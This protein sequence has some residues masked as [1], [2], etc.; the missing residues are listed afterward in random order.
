MKI[1]NSIILPIIPILVYFDFPGTSLGLNMFLCLIIF[2]NS[3]VILLREKNKNI[4]WNQWFLFLCLIIVVNVSV[5]VIKYNNVSFF[6]IIY[7]FINLFTIWIISSKNEIFINKKIYILSLIIL[8]LCSIGIYCAQW[9]VFVI[10]KKTFSGMIP[11]LEI[12]DS[13]SKIEATKGV[14]LVSNG[15]SSNSFC[16]FFS[17]PSHFAMFLLPPLHFLYIYKKRKWYYLAIAIVLFLTIMSTRSGNGIIGLF[18]LSFLDVCYDSEIEKRRK[19]II[20]TIISISLL[21]IF[22]ISWLIPSFREM[23]LRLFV[24]TEQGY[25]KAGYR[26]YRGFTIFFNLPVGNAIYGLGY[27]QITRFMETN[28]FVTMFDYDSGSVE[29]VNFICQMMI[30]FG[31]VGFLTFV[32]FYIDI[33]RN[34]DNCSKPLLI[35]LSFFFLSCSML[36]DYFF[37]FYFFSAIVSNRNANNQ[38]AFENASL[39]YCLEI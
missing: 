16:S 6:S 10:T 36:F 9:L 3:I 18:I 31:L 13:F 2:I 22:A 17:E 20:L 11:F 35:L 26:I 29:Y 4:I 25:S 7:L 24:A 1:I 15:S 14:Y 5:V 37:M 30:Y 19:K 34:C 28:S 33:F 32:G 21:S 38:K 27:S 23:Y 12:S 8:S 39:Q